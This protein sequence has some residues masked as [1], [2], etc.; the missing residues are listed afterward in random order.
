MPAEYESS[1]S[2]NNSF[3]IDRISIVAEDS[4]LLGFIKK[5]NWFDSIGIENYKPFS[6]TLNKKNDTSAAKKIYPRIEPVGNSVQPMTFEINFMTLSI[7]LCHS[8]PSII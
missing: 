3:D 7:K 6:D 5:Q 1:Y 4:F 8:P 2:S